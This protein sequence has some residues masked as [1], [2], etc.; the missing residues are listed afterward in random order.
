MITARATRAS[1]TSSP[2]PSRS[3][4]S[5]WTWRGAS[6]STSAQACRTTRTD[7]SHTPRLGG[8]DGSSRRQ[9]GLGDADPVGGA[10]RQRLV[11]EVVILAVQPPAL[12]GK[13]GRA[14]CR[15]RVCQYV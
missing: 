10:G 7:T 1:A 15:E 9:G 14:S 6:I 5:S 3:R 12:A 8:D 2:S 11:V 4:C 13:I